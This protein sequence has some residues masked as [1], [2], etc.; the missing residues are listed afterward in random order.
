MKTEVIRWVYIL[1]TAVNMHTKKT[2]LNCRQS[3]W[4]IETEK[5]ENGSRWRMVQAS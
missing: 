2:S 3:W 5:E 4:E 1:W